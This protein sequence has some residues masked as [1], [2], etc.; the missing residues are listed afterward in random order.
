MKVEKIKQWCENSIRSI[1]MPDTIDGDIGN[2]AKREWLKGYVSGLGDI[3][4]VVKEAEQRGAE[5]LQ[6]VFI[7]T[8]MVID[9]DTGNEVEV[10]IWKDPVANAVIGIDSTY[11]DQA[12]PGE[13]E[14]EIQSPFNLEITLL[15]PADVI[16]KGPAPDDG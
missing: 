10:E 9:P 4:T 15:L 8:I 16:E 13:E 5:Q 14:A 1:Q 12:A 11:L 2:L 3:V 6:A 7:T